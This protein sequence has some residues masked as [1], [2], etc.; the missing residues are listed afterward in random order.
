M[1]HYGNYYILYNPISQEL[2]LNKQKINFLTLWEYLLYL[3][4]G[5]GWWLIVK[6]A[7]LQVE[8]F[9]ILRVDFKIRIVYNPIHNKQKGYIL[10]PDKQFKITYYAKKHQ[11]HITRLGKWVEGCRIYEDKKGTTHFT[12]WD[13]EADNFRNAS[14][15]WSVRY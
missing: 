4:G 11:K 8:S 14:L 13:I 15:S 1:R 12:Y 7:Q 2:F 9:F 3:D 10:I 5:W 6:T